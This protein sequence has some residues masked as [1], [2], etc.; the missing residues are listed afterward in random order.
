[1]IKFNAF[2]QGWKK[3]DKESDLE[4]EFPYSDDQGNYILGLVGKPESFPCAYK[5]MFFMPNGEG[6]VVAI[7]SFIYDF[8]DQGGE[9]GW[10]QS[11]YTC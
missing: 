10:Q 1:M 4:W 9:F 8:E 5:P 11:N 7:A 2:E 3:L 6:G